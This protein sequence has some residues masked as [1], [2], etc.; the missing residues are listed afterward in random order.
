MKNIVYLFSFLTLTLVVS[1]CS[2]KQ[3]IATVPVENTIAEDQSAETMQEEAVESAPQFKTEDFSAHSSIY[4]FSGEIPSGFEVEYADSI[5]SINIYDPSDAHESIRDKSKIFIR[6]FRASDFLTLSTVTIFESSKVKAG[7]HDAVRYEIEK[8]K[9]IA[10]FPGQPFWRNQRHKLIDIRYDDKK[11]TFFYVF[12][13]SPGFGEEMFE[14]FI[15][16]LIFN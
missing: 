6:Y 15:E 9:G 13:H 14:Q 1:G 7:S 5:E 16:S 4:K 12:S 10:D 3:E 8:K 11:P 2:H